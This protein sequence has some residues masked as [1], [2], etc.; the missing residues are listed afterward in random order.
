MFNRAGLP[1]LQ[2]SRG[3]ERLF[4]RFCCGKKL[5]GGFGCAVF[6]INYNIYSL[7]LLKT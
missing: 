4:L 2:L 1:G 3:T 6:F 7:A 5:A